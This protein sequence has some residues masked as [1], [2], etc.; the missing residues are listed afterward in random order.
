MWSGNGQLGKR[1][2]KRIV[3]AIIAAIAVIAAL[4]AAIMY[5]EKQEGS[6]QAP[7]ADP[8]G[9][10]TEGESAQIDPAVF[11]RIEDDLPDKSAVTARPDAWYGLYES[12][13]GI[14]HETGLEGAIAVCPDVYAWIEVPGCGIDYPIAYCEDAVEPFYYT[15]DIHGDPSDNGMIITDSMNE[16]DFSDPLTLV[17]GHNAEDGTMFAGLAGFRDSDFFEE[18]QYINIYLHDAELKYRIYAC[19]IGPADNML[20]AY[21]FTDPAQF[22]A[23][24]DPMEDIRDLSANFRQTEKPS[25]GDHVIG[26]VTHCDDEDKRLFVYAVL[27]EVRY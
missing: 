7:A 9:G 21:D 5:L 17:Y 24:F 3:L 26:L 25:V 12:S 13:G 20:V 19:F 6:G 2:D 18:N 27:D 10:I 4:I 15:H 8:G 16:D 1:T 14:E 11:D 22:N 23:F